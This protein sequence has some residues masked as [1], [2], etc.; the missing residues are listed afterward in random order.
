M[1]SSNNPLRQYFRRPAVYLK[2]PSG[3]KFYAPGIVNIP[4]TGELPVY[5]M[6]AIDEITSKTPDALFNGAAMVDIIRSC[7]PDIIDPWQINNIDFDSILIAIRAS[8]G[9]SKLEVDSSC[10]KCNQ[11]ESYETDLTKILSKLVAGN[12]NDILTINELSVKFKPMTYAIMNSS[13][14]SQFSIQRQFAEVGALNIDDSIVQRQ[15]AIKKNHDALKAVMMLTIDILSNAIEYI[16]A[17]NIKVDDKEHIQEFLKNCDK[18][19]YESM[20]DFY[21]A[22]KTKTDMQ[23]L[24]LKC[25]HC[26]HEYSQPFTLNISDFFG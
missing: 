18:T 3:G 24:Q 12:Y 19:M 7:V 26:N 13:A 23:P 11:T 4:E 17:P 9:G 6:T 20:R 1:T 16:Q 14:I 25:V 8:S 15:D 5:P 10:P 22:L 2:L 21:S